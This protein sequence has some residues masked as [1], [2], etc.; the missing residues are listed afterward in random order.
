[1]PRMSRRVRAVC[2]V[3]FFVAA[4]LILFLWPSP[5]PADHTRGCMDAVAPVG[6]LTTDFTNVF[7]AGGAFLVSIGFFLSLLFGRKRADHDLPE[8]RAINGL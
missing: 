5:A 4:P 2:G 1:M 3:V 6:D 7:A 8:A